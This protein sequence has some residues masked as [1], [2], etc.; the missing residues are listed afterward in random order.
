MKSKGIEGLKKEVRKSLKVAE[1][2]RER[3]QKAGIRAVINEFSTTVCMERPL[4]ENFVHKWQ[5]ACESDIAHVV[6][7]PNHDK[8]KIDIF[9]EEYTKSREETGPR[10]PDGPDSSLSQFINW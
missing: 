7:M 9:V 4:D 3:L 10:K 5:L 2:L 8:E 6:V 1:Y